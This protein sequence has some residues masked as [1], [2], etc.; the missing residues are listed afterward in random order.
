MS[1]I[2]IAFIGVMNGLFLFVVVSTI[3]NKRHEK[4]RL[5]DLRQQTAQLG[6]QLIEEPG[7]HGLYQ[8]DNFKLFNRGQRRKASNLIEGDSGEVK[9]SIFD[10]EFTAGTDK[11][12]TV[13]KQTIIAL[14][15]KRLHFPKFQMRPEMFLDKLGPVM[16]LQDLDFE[17]H[18]EFSKLFVLEGSDEASIRDFFTP[19]VLEFFERHPNN[20]LE[21]CD[22]T[23]FFYRDQIVREA[24]ELKDL[25]ALAYET[26]HAL[27]AAHKKPELVF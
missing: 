10:Y 23:L 7:N 21:A 1:L 20:S 9:I 15:S 5:I 18:P 3:L 13:Y 6:L 11:Y 25:L 8:F 26:Y 12:K 19:A 27:S 22:D 4:Q 24:E 14:R 2:G 16:G 17:T